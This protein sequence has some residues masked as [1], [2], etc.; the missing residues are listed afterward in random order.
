M[1]EKTLSELIVYQ[2]VRKIEIK[3]KLV[4]GIWC[5]KDFKNIFIIL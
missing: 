5:L 1:A 2:I 3:G 4:R